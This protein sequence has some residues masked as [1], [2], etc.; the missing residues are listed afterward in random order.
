MFS[1]IISNIYILK[2]S[3]RKLKSYYY[4]NKNFLL[5]RKKI[6]DFE[7]NPDKMEDTFSIM[8]K[9]LAEPN[10][11]ESRKYINKLMESIDFYV[12]PKKFRS[13][14][15]SEEAPVSNIIQRDKKMTA[16]NFFINAD[17]EIYI[18]DTLW[19]VLAA[20]MDKD[21]HLLSY[22]VYG[23]TINMS[24]LFPTEDIIN[25]SSRSLFNRYFNKYTAW[26]N[27]AFDA[28]EKN[29]TNHKDSVLLSLDIK[30]FY[31]SVAFNFEKLGE[32]FDDHF[33]ISLIAPLT[34][35]LKNTYSIYLSKIVK[36]RN[37]LG[38]LD[39]NETPL[40]IG[41]FSSMLLGNIYLRKL[42]KQ[43]ESIKELSY[44]GRYVDDILLVVNK[45]ISEGTTNSRILED[46]LIKNNIV[47]DKG[48]FLSLKKYPSLKI[49]SDKVKIL[50]INHAESKAIIDIY[51]NT[52]R[53][54]PS[55]M[56]PIPNASLDLQSFD[57]TAYNIDKLTKE[58]KIRDIGFG[59]IDPF[60]VGR[61]FS[62]LPYRYAHINVGG[63]KLRK[64]ID[65]HIDQVTKFFAGSQSIEFHTHWLN[66]IYFL[67][68]TQ[69]NRQL[70]DFITDTKDRIS[71]L[72]PDLDKTMYKRAPSINK[73]TKDT[74]MQHL[75][76]CLETAL[77]LDI[78][79][80][81]KH[82]NHYRDGVI[83]IMNSNMFQHNFTAIPLANYLKYDRPISY[84]KMS[85]NDVGKYPTEIEK[86]FKFI[87]SPRFIHYDELLFLLF[88]NH[89]KNNLKGQSFI[90]TQE[91]LI[92]KYAKINHISG[93]PFY[94]DNVPIFD[95]YDD[96]VLEKIAIPTDNTEIPSNVNIAV[97]SIE[98][99]SEKCFN[100][101]DRW[102]NISIDE[103]KLLYDI[104]LQSHNCFNTKERGTMLLVFP[105]LYFPIY[106][107]RD[108]I[109]FAREDQIGIV[110]GLQYI[111]NDNNQVHNYLA[112]I[113]PFKSGKKG[114]KNVFLHIREKNDYSPI[115]FE[116][117][118]KRGLQCKN[119]EVANYQV[120]H[121]KGVRLAPIVCYELTDITVR[122]LMKGNC[123]II[124]AS[125]FNPDTTYFS[126]IIDSTVRDIHAFIVQANT[127]HLGDSRVTGPY[128]RDSKDI[129]KIKG[130]D[131]DHVVIGTVE[132]KKL[133]DF[134][135]NYNKEF[136][137]KIK[138]IQNERLKKNP[139]YPKKNRTKPDIKPLSARFK[140]K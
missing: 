126:N 59:N 104:L 28:L 56:D 112:T 100:G 108:L 4:Y 71:N 76:I 94:I 8:A 99:T 1:N 119:R 13:N 19:T 85:L 7:F 62:A 64:E 35:I 75:I 46:I 23:N 125:V 127:S 60:R 26:R 116:E 102:R 29:Y 72:L 136:E 14:I 21:N 55:Q 32:Y 9:V 3:Y 95:N 53:I 111:K 41:F 105:E 130:G 131:N 49:Q 39:K 135:A 17:I 63:T 27:K 69:R 98:I 45:T 70:R 18:F 81:D 139:N 122:A 107:I 113:L 78:D 121:W 110:T 31:Y 38:F 68:L 15:N 97:G 91:V 106:W 82:F 138:R 87:W 93:I 47:E 118:A 132:F 86:S 48:E 114:Y 101:L 133:K 124:A 2:G 92:D 16:V 58:N 123:D 40:P 80:V 73:K 30:S 43:I 83:K 24:A 117:L 51:N 22:N 66:Y 11:D 20:K 50:Y 12:L 67:V 52:I 90:Y 44:Y 89:H 129:Y 61:F 6:T 74:L 77:S 137:R 5:M 128:D 109:R 33:Y 134:Q 84:C 25:Y 115:E 36:F 65:I 54:I 88:Y 120:F 42:D 57:E 34:N 10:S 103:K 37:D 96:Y 140:N 79:T